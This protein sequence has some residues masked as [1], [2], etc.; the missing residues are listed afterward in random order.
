[1]KKLITSVLLLVAITINAQE[2]YFTTY[3]F[4]VEPS[5]QSAIVQLM[6]DYFTAHKREG[7]TVSLWENHFNDKDNNYSHSVV[8]AGSLDAMGAQYGNDGGSEWTLFLTQVNQ[9]IKENF[10]AAMGTRLASWGDMNMKYPVQNYYI[11]HVEDEPTF[12]AAY[13]KYQTSAVRKD[14]M[15]MV[16]SISTGRGNDGGTHWAITGYKDFKSAMGGSNA[17]MTA[18]EKTARDKAWKT[19][20]ET[21][22]GA[23]LVRSGT[24]VMVG[25]W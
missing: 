22:G 20:T 12:L 23:H 21:N 14:W 15:N 17:V 8:F 2:S 16:G 6:S 19:F 25:Q 5:Q 1:M 24:R 7:V 11:V 13:T 3:N 9:H 4:T 18:A 10:S